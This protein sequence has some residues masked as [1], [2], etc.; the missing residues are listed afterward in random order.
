MSPLIRLAYAI[1]LLLGELGNFIWAEASSTDVS[2]RWRVT[3]YA[4][5][6][7][8]TTD[9]D[10]D[11]TASSPVSC[12]LPLA[13]ADHISYTTLPIHPAGGKYTTTKCP[14]VPVWPAEDRRLS[15]PRAPPIVRI[16]WYKIAGSEN[17]D[18]VAGR[19]TQYSYNT[20]GAVSAG[21]KLVFDTQ[22]SGTTVVG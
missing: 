18:N 13:S 4:G 14:L 12:S 10:L 8:A 11:F 3:I 22:C 17:A 7:G 9:A 5:L 1:S 6:T 20:A 2:I 16:L 15:G 21:M 19:F